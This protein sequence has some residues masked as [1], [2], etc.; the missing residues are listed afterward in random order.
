MPSA[1]YSKKR[2]SA[3]PTAMAA[4]T[5]AIPVAPF[6]ESLLSGGTSIRRVCLT[7]EM[8]R[9]GTDT[10]T[11]YGVNPR[12]RRCHRLPGLGS[13]R[14]LVQRE[15][16]ARLVEW[17]VACQALG[18]IHAGPRLLGG[19]ENRVVPVLVAQH[20]WD[21]LAPAG[22]ACHCGIGDELIRHEE[23]VGSEDRFFL[24]IELR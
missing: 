23:A 14:D 1:G 17:L 7:T 13:C 3:H 10:S 19:G 15:N 8:P 22:I 21:V 9:A 20:L 4:S 16:K 11:C 6:A 2:E 18:L 24:G 12:S 5:S